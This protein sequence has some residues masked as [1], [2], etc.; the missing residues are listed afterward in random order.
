MLHILLGYPYPFTGDPSLRLL[1]RG[2]NRLHPH[3]PN[4]APPIT[5]GHLLRVFQHLDHQ[6]S[7]ECCV[8]SCG[9]FLFFSLSRLGSIL[10]KSVK[11][12]SRTPTKYL[13]RD[14]VDLGRSDFITLSFLHTKTIQ[15]GQRVLCIP[16]LRSDSPL[17]P[18]AAYHHALVLL[19]G[20]HTA[21]FAYRD[22]RGHV[23]PLLPRLF[24][25]TFRMLL[26]RACIPDANKFRG[27][28]FRRGGASWAFNSG[29]PG[30]LIQVMGD[31]KS[32]AYKVYL[33]FSLSSKISIARRLVACLP[34]MP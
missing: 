6:D 25:D 18:V 29:V 21:A 31:W 27:H 13:S 33:E 19:A 24:V 28:S 32:D 9:L 8:F 10:P 12:V 3:V 26:R 17:C 2:I 5:P 16:L 20:V 1:L 15:F 23:L 4:R 14:R 22:T 11:A 30:E 34:G 7:L